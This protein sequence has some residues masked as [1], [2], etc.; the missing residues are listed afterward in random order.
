MITG[1]CLL[2]TSLTHVLSGQL[3][4]GWMMAWLGH[5]SSLDMVTWW[6]LRV[7]GRKVLKGTGGEAWSWKTISSFLFYPSKQVT[8]Q[9][10]F[11]RWE[12]SLCLI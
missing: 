8:D 7:Q 12:H 10:R 1:G 3:A 5:M 9:P 4:A 6:L 2:E 11:K